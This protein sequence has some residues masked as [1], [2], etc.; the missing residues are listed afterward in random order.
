MIE[1]QGICDE[2]R[3]VRADEH[4]AHTAE[5]HGAGDRRDLALLEP[6]ADH[7]ECGLGRLTAWR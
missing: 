7:G 2:A 4:R 1:F 6:G 3:D 5:Q